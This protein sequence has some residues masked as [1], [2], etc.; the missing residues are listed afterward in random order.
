[1]I[2][3]KVDL[4]HARLRRV[5]AHRLASHR[6]HLDQLLAKYAFRR[7]REVFQVWATRI[8]DRLARLHRGMRWRLAA[9]RDRVIRARDAY[10]LRAWPEHLAQRR[11]EAGEWM[12]RLRPA[13]AEAL[14]ARRHRITGYQDRLRALSPR[15][16]MERGYC[17]VR[18]PDG[19]LLRS[20]E[21]L[22]VGELLRVEFAR[23]EAD[24]RVEAVR[25]GEDDGE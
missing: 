17:L 25:A 9:A 21:R 10:G 24:A 7:P 20:S 13:L 15:L 14:A 3:T 16:V 5:L 18:G 6:Q 2:R 12:A 8:A 4:M 22:E 19:T 11:E 23:G 1:M